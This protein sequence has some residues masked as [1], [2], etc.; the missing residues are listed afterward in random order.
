M[1]VLC[2]PNTSTIS[3]M[4][5]LNQGSLAWLV[6]LDTSLQ[7]KCFHYSHVHSIH[8]PD[9]INSVIKFWLIFH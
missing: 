5:I 4:G 9:I 8:T 6:Y 3:S 7:L 2:F 1:I